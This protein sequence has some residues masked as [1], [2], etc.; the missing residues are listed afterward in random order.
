[1]YDPRYNNN[2]IDVTLTL[3]TNPYI[4][5]DVLSVTQEIPNFFHVLNAGVNITSIQVL[6]EDKQSGAFDILFF[7]TDIDVGTINNAYNLT[8]AEMR[9]FVGMASVTAS[10]YH[11]F[12]NNSVAWLGMGYEDMRVF[13]IKPTRNSNSIY[14]A[15]ISQDTKT[16]TAN[17]LSL[18][19]ATSLVL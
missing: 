17:A 1:M 2:V 7:D 10:G 13:I 12:T 9:S 14:M 6:D 4:I 16:Y 3:D 15:T 18:K 19:I 11:A 8:D 5:G